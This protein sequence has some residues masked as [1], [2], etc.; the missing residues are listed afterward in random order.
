MKNVRLPKLFSFPFQSE[1]RILPIQNF[2]LTAI[3]HFLVWYFYNAQYIQII[4]FCVFVTY[5]S[6]SMESGKVIEESKNHTMVWI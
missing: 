1:S 2:K 4:P 3:L 6:P 5:L